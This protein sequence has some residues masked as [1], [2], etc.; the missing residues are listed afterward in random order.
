MRIYRLEA[1]S[2]LK[3]NEFTV[4]SHICAESVRVY[5]LETIWEMSAESV[6][7]YLSDAISGPNMARFSI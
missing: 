5:R 1:I 4:S 3:V 6:W 2:E 7:I